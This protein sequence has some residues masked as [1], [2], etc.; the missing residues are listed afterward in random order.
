MD[1]AK[2][3]VSDFMKKSGHKDTTVHESVNPAVVQ[4]TISPERHE[5]TQVAIDKEVHQDHY[6]TSVQ[7]V[8]DQEILPEKH[9]HQVAQ[10][11]E[12]VYT[13]GNK[14]DDEARLAAD[15]AQFRDE[16]VIQD[17]KYSR[18]EAPVVGGEH[19][20]HHVHE[21]IQPVV[22]KETVQPEVIHTTK[23]QHEVHHNASQHHGVSA[24]PEVSMSELQAKGIGL[25][26]REERYDAFEG[27]PKHVGGALGNKEHLYSDGTGTSGTSRTTR[28][29]GHPLDYHD[30]ATS[31]TTG[32]LEHGS[33]TGGSST[34]GTTG[35]DTYGT[36]TYDDTTTGTKTKP[37]LMDKIN[38]KVDASGDGKAGFMK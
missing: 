38:P 13:H 18:S 11:E 9:S 2:A 30:S 34:T 10:A 27:E 7:P 19:V 23:L 31:G 28:S 25:G 33:H 21:T 3:A 32:G 16:R 36:D 8:R 37:S 15:Q 20:H 26:G 12:R 29:Q 17:T 22:Q 14:A 1:K 6:H 24:L 4:E 5:Q 35:T